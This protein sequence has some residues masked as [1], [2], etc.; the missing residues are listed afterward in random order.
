MWFCESLTHTLMLKHRLHYSAKLVTTLVHTELNTRTAFSSLYSSFNASYNPA[1][2]M[3][4]NRTVKQTIIDTASYNPVHLMAR[5][6]WNY[7]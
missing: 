3:Y 2:I 4:E 6:I 7:I 1:C 5:K